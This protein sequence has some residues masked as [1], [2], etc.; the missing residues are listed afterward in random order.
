MKVTELKPN[1]SVTWNVLAELK[2][3]EGIF[4]LLSLMKMMEKQKCVLNRPA[5]KKQ[6]IFMH[7]ALLVGDAT[8]KA[9]ANTAKQE[10]EKPLEA[11]VTENNIS[12]G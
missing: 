6:M 8:W 3:G 5:G 2:N 11:K 9:F 1:E 12:N 4:L 10:K 7:H